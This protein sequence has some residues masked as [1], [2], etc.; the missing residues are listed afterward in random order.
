MHISE[1]ADR[2]VDDPKKVVHVGEV[3]KVRV[4]KVDAQLKRIALS[5]RVEPAPSA[6]PAAE[7]QQPRKAARPVSR[8]PQSRPA[9]RPPQPPRPLATI[10]DL[11]RKF[12]KGAEK[13]LF[14][15]KPKFNV[16]QFM[17]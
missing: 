13:K 6:A 11:K 17:K 7:A 1:I 2:F 16:K 15:V 12:D 3:V 9:P 8:P 5:M 4:T 14:T 10:A